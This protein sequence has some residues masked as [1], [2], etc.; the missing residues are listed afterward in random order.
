MRPFFRIRL[1]IS[2]SLTQLLNSVSN[3]AS[4]GIRFSLQVQVS[5][6]LLDSASNVASLGFLGTMVY[7]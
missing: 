6:G 3:V 1:G 2:D 5:L 7:L 4:L